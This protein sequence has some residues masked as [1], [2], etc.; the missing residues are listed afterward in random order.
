MWTTSEARDK[1]WKMNFFGAIF[2]GARQLQSWLRNTSVG[3]FVDFNISSFLIHASISVLWQRIT[4]TIQPPVQ[5][6]SQALPPYIIRFGRRFFNEKWKIPLS[7]DFNSSRQLSFS[8]SLLFLL[9]SWSLSLFLSLSRMLA[10]LLSR[11]TPHLLAVLL[12]FD[13]ASSTEK[14]L[15][16]ARKLEKKMERG[17]IGGCWATQKRR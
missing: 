9:Q 11:T 2:S 8:L 12:F 4:R 13:S 10:L 16:R 1:T 14:R 6:P 7:R 15:T 3:N 17:S 5:C